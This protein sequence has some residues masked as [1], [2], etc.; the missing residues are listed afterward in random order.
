MDADKTTKLLS[1][2]PAQTYEEWKE[3]AVKLLKGRPFEKTLVT[4]TYEGFD[5][6][7]IYTK[8]V[9]HGLSHV[10]DL[11]GQGSQVRGS[12]LSGYI[13]AGWT[14][15]Q[16]F[17][18]P[19]AAD[20]NA[21]AIEQIKKGQNE[22][23]IRLDPATR[24]GLNADLAK[25]EEV[26]IGG[27]SIG[28]TEDIK[29][30]LKG[31]DLKTTSI[32]LQCRQA[33]PAIYSLLMAALKE[34]DVNPADLKGCIGM[35]PAGSLAETGTATSEFEDILD[36]VAALLEHAETE[37]PNL[38]ILDIQGHA[39][40][41]GGASSSQE[42]A[43][44]LS[45]AV[46]YI[47]AMTT[48]GIPVETVVPRMRLSVSIGGNY[49]IEIAKLRALRLLWSRVMDAFEVPES[50]RTI[51]VH[52]KT[53]LWN[54]TAFDPYVNMLRT[55]TEAFSAV[56]G[57]C[58]SLTVG[59]FDEVLRDSNAF[60][61]RIAFNTHAILSDECD[62]RR[63]IDPAGGSWAVEALTD[64]VAASAWKIFQGIEADGGIINVLES[65]E[66]QNE[67]E[68]VCQKKNK[69][70]QCR[71][72]V[73]VGTNSYPNATEELLAPAEIDYPA[74]R[75]EL[76]NKLSVWKNNRQNAPLFTVLEGISTT[77]G[78]GKVKAL[79]ESAASG[80]TLAELQTSAGLGTLH[81]KARTIKLNRAAGEFEK[82]RMAAHELE[83]KG[84]VPMI[85]QLNMGPS[86]RYRIRADWTS[87]FFQVGGFKLLNEEDY[88]TNAD[89]VV[90]LGRGGAK[91]AV[92][93]SDDET[94]ANTV[95][96]LTRAIKDNCGEVAVYVAGA[97]GGNEAAWKAA[98]VDGF[99]NIRVNNYELNRQLLESLG[100]SL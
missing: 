74:E 7:P 4:P 76:A 63:V 82:L 87:S 39:Y 57:G 29:T 6:Q 55:T 75:K 91:I 48:R 15:S 98:G 25:P 67:V 1:E 40:H 34:M 47:K 95:E 60:S 81:E 51:H 99:V 54:K 70:I 5:L 69:N 72:D 96:D 44:I 66:F 8:E 73:I 46:L 21:A 83:A 38:Q 94:Y 84:E 52:A 50:V 18:G 45:A 14:I 35:D 23:N 33:A 32:Y 56:V 89:A 100:A 85:H 43:A 88:E 9:L 16:E 49:F 20:A 37:A 86:R 31:V 53:G 26:G 10:S 30:L 58:D 71:R 93:T 97:P 36:M 13:E 59:P 41:N 3:A 77:R 92:I 27:V 61:R 2:F 68:A 80:A 64:Q 12:R 65:G 22:M 28:T 17:T 11:P 78:I 62:M 79:I 19:K 42:L 24:K 90:A